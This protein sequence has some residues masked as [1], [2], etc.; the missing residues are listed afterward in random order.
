MLQDYI[1]K[2]NHQSLD[3]QQEAENALAQARSID[4]KHHYFTT[5]ETDVSTQV[6]TISDLIQ[7][8]KALPLA[9]VFISAK[10]C[11]CVKGMETT[12]G[13]EILKGYRPV[14]DATVIK[15]LREKGAII[16][17]KTIQDAFGF[18]SFATN[19]GKCY[20]RPTNPI[21]Q[22]HVCGGSSGGAAGIAQSATFPHVALAQS[23]GGSIVCPASFCDVVGLCPTYSLV[24]RNGLISYSNTLD[25]IG[26]IGKRI[27]DCALVLE[28]IAGYDPKDSTSTEHEKVAYADFSDALSH[29]KKLKIGVITDFMDPQKGIDQNVCDTIKQTIESIKAQGITVEEISLPYIAEYALSAYYLISMTEASTNLAALCGLRYGQQ[30]DPKKHYNDYFTDM[31]STH[32]NQESKRRILLGTFARMS[33]FRD[34]Y[35]IKALKLRTKIIEEYKNVFEKYDILCSPTMPFP[36]P[37]FE[38]VD[39]LEPIQEYMADNITVG[40]NLAGMPHVS[41]PLNRTKDELPI[42]MLLVSDHFQEKKIIDMA[43]LIQQ[44]QEQTQ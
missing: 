38:K 4:S 17:G 41:V 11:I 7:T 18:G 42:G 1:Q 29:A 28:A 12:A 20:D 27:E 44:M 8:G 5:I 30:T 36:A 43:Y 35:Y 33:G 6:K 10:D 21:N 22:A 25:K 31:R 23:T 32:F 3:L 14:F 24:S 2:I 39:S 13:S 34:A 26:P 40:P 37:T 16:I 15:R 19:V 9:G